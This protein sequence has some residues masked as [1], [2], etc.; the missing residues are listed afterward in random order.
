MLLGH[1]DIPAAV[2]VAVEL[3]EIAPIMLA[4]NDVGRAA[5]AF[6]LSR[7]VAQARHFARPH[8]KA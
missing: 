3:P 2:Q 4:R 6:P 5:Q 7:L 8:I 1:R